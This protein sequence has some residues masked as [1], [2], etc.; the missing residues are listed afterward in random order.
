MLC[1]CG[2]K[3][4]PDA[5]PN[6]LPEPH[7]PRPSR[8]AGS[9]YGPSPAVPALSYSNRLISRLR[10]EFFMPLRPDWLMKRPRHLRHAA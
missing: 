5:A 7:R 9:F 6:A 3:L 2:A 4:N 1:L 8:A 10:L